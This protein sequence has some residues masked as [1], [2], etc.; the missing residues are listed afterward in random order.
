MIKNGLNIV[1]ILTAFYL[2]PLG[3][4]I[5]INAVNSLLRTTY[6]DLYKDMETA[7]YKWDNPILLLIVTGIVLFLLYSDS[8]AVWN[9]SKSCDRTARQGNGNL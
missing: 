3:L 4:M 9:G 6:F 5:I 2:Y 8:I 7:K 1:K